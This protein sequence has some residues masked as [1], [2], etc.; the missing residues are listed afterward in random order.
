VYLSRKLALRH[1]ALK[2]Y[3]WTWS[4]SNVKNLKNHYLPWYKGKCSRFFLLVCMFPPHLP[5]LSPATSTPAHPWGSCLNDAQLQWNQVSRILAPLSF[6][7]SVVL[8][9]QILYLKR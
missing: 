7:K 8:W 1:A 4:W 6:F 5:L 2:R 9:H 3:T